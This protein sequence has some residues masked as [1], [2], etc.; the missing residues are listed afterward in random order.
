V[1]E[2]RFFW[3]DHRLRAATSAAVAPAADALAGIGRS[4]ASSPSI[5]SS[6]RARTTG[7]VATIEATD[8]EALLVEKG[9]RPHVITPRGKVLRLADGRF[10]TGP[11]AHPGVRPR[12]FLAP[13]LRLWT[14]A[15]QRTAGATLR[16]AG[17]GRRV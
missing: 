4:I 9:S 8:P 10:V 11:V 13:L 7:N 17:F 3:N 15:Y 6:I 2:V 14:D 1:S 5:A 12:P 16:A